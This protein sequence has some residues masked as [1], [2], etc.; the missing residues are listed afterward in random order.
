MNLQL[1]LVTGL[2]TTLLLL[3]AIG[4]C[5]LLG[6][7]PGARLVICR[8]SVVAVIA[9]A[10]GSP[11][12]ATRPRPLVPIRVPA[13]HSTLSI[14]AQ[15]PISVPDNAVATPA[16]ATVGSPATPVDWLGIA[17]AIWLC[18]VGVMAAFLCL[19]Y[20]MLATIR[21]RSSVVTTGSLIHA[22]R[23]ACADFQIR[24]PQIRAEESLTTP[25]VAGFWRPTL[26]VPKAWISGD[27]PAM[28]EGICRHEMAHLAAHDLRWQ[29]LYRLCTVAIWPQPCLWVIA[30]IATVA[31]EEMCDRRVLASGCLPQ[32]YAASL[33]GLRD[34][35]P[36]SRFISPVG[37][38]LWLQVRTADRVVAQDAMI[39]R[40]IQTDAAWSRYSVV[41]D[42]PKDSAAITF[43]A[44]LAGTGKVSMDDFSL[45]TV[46]PSQVATTGQ[47]DSADAPKYSDQPVD[48]DFTQAI[49]AGSQLVI[50]GWGSS[51]DSLK[52][53]PNMSRA[54]KPALLAAQEEQ[55]AQ[56]I[57]ATAYLGKR[58][59]F[60]AFVKTSGAMRGAAVVSLPGGGQFRTEMDPRKPAADSAGWH[61][62]TTVVDVPE[63]ATRIMF[64][65]EAIGAGKAW[66][67]NCSLSVVDPK[68]VPLT[69]STPQP[70][71]T[72][73]K[74]LPA[75][76]VNLDFQ[77]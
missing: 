40:A 76:P 55:L 5:L 54:G 20:G 66:F 52:A 68:S 43:G 21:R 8:A 27:E 70:A 25:F 9:I 19:G 62:V 12:L 65:L 74:S 61:E 2:Q 32:E 15:M 4:A 56:E 34:A 7:S 77:S 42:V 69:P 59:E 57:L 39:D 22:V 10:L 60:K 37:I 13:W 24:E 51:H 29:L 14:P 18:G 72:Q 3:L 73:W 36:S 35:L 47:P 58:I 30:R 31:G 28:L 67:S 64:G 38:G 17:R 33:L 53:D 46:D 16:A 26:Y 63:T 48:L 71:D 23:T 11:W 6:K 44:W 49:E 41:L 45:E 75:A 50:P 1:L